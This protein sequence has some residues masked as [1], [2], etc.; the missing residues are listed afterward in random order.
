VALDRPRGAAWVRNGGLPL[1]ARGLNSFPV[2]PHLAE[3]GRIKVSLNS[4][5]KRTMAAV[6]GA[7]A[8][9]TVTVG[10]A[11]SPAQAASSTR[12]PANG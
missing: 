11:V 3:T 8:L 1:L 4:S 2:L 10:A 5:F 7:F 6:I 12:A 9:S